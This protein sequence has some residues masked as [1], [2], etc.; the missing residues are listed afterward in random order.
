M[1]S[2]F[3]FDRATTSSYTGD[4]IDSTNATRMP[5]EVDDC[6]SP[7]CAATYSSVVPLV[8]RRKRDQ[9][10]VGCSGRAAGQEGNSNV[11]F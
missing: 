2:V 10:Y 1:I 6:A 11:F 9:R 4:S 3:A 5:Y 8:T 7:E